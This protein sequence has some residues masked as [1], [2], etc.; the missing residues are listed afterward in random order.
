MINSMHPMHRPRCSEERPGVNV[1]LRAV[2]T[3]P[4]TL[5]RLL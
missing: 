2:L 3:P 5:T 1:P 4:T